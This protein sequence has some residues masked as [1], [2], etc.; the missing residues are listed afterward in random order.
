[1]LA[2][3]VR[4]G[5]ALALIELRCRQVA[6]EHL[7]RT[8]AAIDDGAASH[9]ERDEPDLLDVEPST[10]TRE[11]A[12][13]LGAL[14]TVTASALRDADADRALY[15]FLPPGSDVRAVGALAHDVSSA[16]R[17]AAEAG[18][19]FRTAVLR[20]GGRRIVIRLPAAMSE[21]WGTLVAVGET[22]RPGLAYRQV[23]QAAAALGA[24]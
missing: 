6:A 3:S 10:R 19:A 12:S 13:H 4:P 16:M 2:V 22:A 24:L 17:Q 15:L 7:A 18:V 11:L 9:D 23:E 21:P 5:G 8:G 1:V 14:G 20:S